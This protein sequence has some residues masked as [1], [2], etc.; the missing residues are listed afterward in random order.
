[1]ND[2]GS[3]SPALVRRLILGIL[4]Y[5]SRTGHT[6]A[7][8]PR[9]FIMYMYSSTSTSLPRPY[10]RTTT[11][12]D[13]AFKGLHATISS[14]LN[15]MANT[16]SEALRI[17]EGVVRDAGDPFASPDADVILRSSDN[18][19]FRFY[20]LILKLASPVFTDMFSLPAP[21]ANAAGDEVKYGLPVICMAEDEQA[22]HVLLTI[23]HPGLMP[24][25]ST[26]D[27]LAVALRL[28]AK[29]RL[30]NATSINILLRR[31]A[32]TSPERVFAIAWMLQI[33]ELALLAARESLKAPYTQYRRMTLKIPEFKYLPAH[34]L[35]QL[36]IFQA[37]C[38]NDAAKIYSDL[39]W[40]DADQV[41]AQAKEAGEVIPF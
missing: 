14:H 1:M 8:A 15:Q 11:Y 16:Q 31:H 20:R 13:C 41:P 4:F 28:V 2:S 36:M 32:Q 22:M 40:L 38:R 3:A 5:D 27:D 12:V 18:V 17:L 34:T 25:I 19:D 26:L 6:A 33:R 29:F 24:N 35:Q 37:R 7:A 39:T 21:P 23:C 9:G 30:T 10:L